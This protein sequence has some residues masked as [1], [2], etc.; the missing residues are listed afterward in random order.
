MKYD[1]LLKGGTVLD[2][3]QGLNAVCDVAIADGKIAAIEPNIPENAAT[4]TVF[5]P[6]KYVTP[7]LVDI[8]AHVYHGV[9]TWGIR[10]DAVC[11]STGTTTIV[12][13]GSPSWATFPGVPRVHRE[14]R[15][16]RNPYLYS[17]LR[18]W[19]SLRPGR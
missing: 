3:A 5:V 15:P 8:H 14:T 9:T 10:A 6:N 16:Y 12:D 2:A 7:G 17:H 18:N 1:I 13:A 4:Q 19:A 11:P